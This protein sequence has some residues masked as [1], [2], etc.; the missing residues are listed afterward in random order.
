MNAAVYTLPFYLLFKYSPIGISVQ[1][2]DGAETLGPDGAEVAREGEDEEEF[3]GEEDA[4]FIPF[5]WPKEEER[6]FY[7]G[8]DPEW[9]EFLKLAKDQK[10]H[11]EIHCE[12][13]SEIGG[14]IDD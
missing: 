8:S 6:T 3:E 13:R 5:S 11:R 7:R 2:D 14:I 12:F 1:I 4:T 9:Q 10:R